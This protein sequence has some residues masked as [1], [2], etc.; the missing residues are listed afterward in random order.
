MRIP[1]WSNYGNAEAFAISSLQQ[2]IDI[3]DALDQERFIAVSLDDVPPPKYKPIISMANGQPQNLNTENQRLNLS[4]STESVEDDLIHYDFAYCG[5]VDSQTRMI[6]E[7][8]MHTISNFPEPLTPTMW[9]EPDANSF[10]VRGKHYKQDKKK[11]HAG[12]SMLRLIAVDIL[13]VKSVILHGFANHPKERIQQA[14]AREAELKKKGSNDESDIPP[15]TF[16]LNITLPGNPLH[17]MLFYFAVDDMSVINGSN[18]TPFSKLANEF[19]FGDSDDFRDHTF[20][21]I[22]QIVEGNFI[23]R[24]AVGSTPAI[25]GTKLKQY[26]IRGERFFELILDVGS[27]SV[28]AG[29]TGLASGYVSH[30][31]R[32]YF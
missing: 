11:Y 22:P 8:K 26:Y 21:L 27:S 25:M 29:V 12:K 31:H 1:Y 5:E 32:F 20:K 17:H 19:F 13:R 3:K 18:G 2:M 4:K 7:E 10:K 24:R 15:F 6:S 14:L 28:A 23:V 30:Q 16:L 9:A